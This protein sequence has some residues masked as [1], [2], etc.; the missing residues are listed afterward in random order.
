VHKSD[1]RQF[2]VAFAALV[3]GLATGSLALYWAIWWLTE[4]TQAALLFTAPAV[5]FLMPIIGVFVVAAFRNL[6]RPSPDAGEPSPST[7]F[8]A[9]AYALCLLPFWFASVGLVQG[10]V[11]LALVLFVV[12]ALSAYLPLRAA[13]RVRLWA[14]VQSSSE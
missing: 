4:S 7:K 9:A 13:Y 3:A 8:A 5:A 10:R 2:V 14:N 1:T 11:A 12:Y 6:R